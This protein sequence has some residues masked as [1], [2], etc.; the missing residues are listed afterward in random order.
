[1]HQF[2]VWFSN[3]L[4]INS[5]S[6]QQLQQ[7]AQQLQ[8]VTHQFQQVIEQLQQMTQELQSVDKPFTNAPTASQSPPKLVKT[9]SKWAI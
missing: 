5:E 4:S 6:H 9:K 1:M 7:V 8:Q 2:C 3:L